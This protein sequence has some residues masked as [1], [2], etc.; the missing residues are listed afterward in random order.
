MFKLVT[1]VLFLFSAFIAKATNLTIYTEQFPPYNYL[2]N[3][4]IVGINLDIIK[5]ACK[6]AQIKCTFKLY[7]WL[8]A[9][10]AALKYENAGV[11]ST[12]R[13][14]ER[15][16]EFQWVG[17]LVYSKN[18]FYKLVN[19]DDIQVTS[20]QDLLNYTVS[21]QNGDIYQDV[22]VDLGY[23]RGK[24]LLQ[25]SSK[26]KGVKLF[27]EGKLDLLIATDKTLEHKLGQ[28]GYDSKQ[29]VPIYPLTL[30]K[31]KG[32]YLALNKA[33]PKKIVDKLQKAVDQLR[34]S[35]QFDVIDAQYEYVK[36][37]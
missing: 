20:E 32:N 1:T 9:Y 30:P 16:A 27:Y 14:E 11:M 33:V 35:G 31:S 3:N 34:A 22:L 17:P 2:K 26:Y 15:E 7:P 5:Q 37:N 4:K 13:S 29:L 25:V 24:N 18:Y 21:A 10:K 23:V 8:R 28:Y 36:Q 6:N 19:R 12:S